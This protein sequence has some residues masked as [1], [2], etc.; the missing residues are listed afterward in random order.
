MERREM[1]AWGI[2]GLSCVCA[3]GSYISHR[4]TARLL[5]KSV[6]EIAKSTP[7]EIEKEVVDAVA[8]EALEM[9]VDSQVDDIL[10]D[11]RKENERY[12]HGKIDQLVRA[13]VEKK[14]TDIATQVVVTY[15]E[16]SE[17]AILESVGKHAGQI[18]TKKIDS[19]LDDIYKQYQRRLDEVNDMYV[20]M[21]G[22][23]ANRN[24]LTLVSSMSPGLHVTL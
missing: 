4:R 3:I 8:Q 21:M 2:A 19:Q 11:I 5:K 18:V 6:E 17:D 14:A 7:I 23:V 10:D 16:I 12:A 9:K 13:E 1:F 24:D 15:E 20:K 22:R